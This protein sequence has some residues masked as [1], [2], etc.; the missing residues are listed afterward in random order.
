MS[1]RS[2]FKGEDNIKRLRVIFN[3]LFLIVKIK[4]VEFEI[5]FYDIIVIRIQYSI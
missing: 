4:K 1:V 2:I 3:I 5:L